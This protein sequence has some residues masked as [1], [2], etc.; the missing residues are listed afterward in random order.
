MT[1]VT[2]LEKYTYIV[3]THGFC[4]QEEQT[5]DKAFTEDLDGS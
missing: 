4:G 3:V 5:A 2:H 1:P